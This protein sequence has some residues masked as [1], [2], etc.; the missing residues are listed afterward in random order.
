MA[1]IRL[2]CSAVA[3]VS[4]RGIEWA[5]RRRNAKELSGGGRGMGGRVEPGFLS[6]YMHIQGLFRP[7]TEQRLR[8][9]ATLLVVETLRRAGVLESGRR[10]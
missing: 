7:G 9:S 2:G 5:L 6:S 8:A 3:Q 1:W 4:Q 10:S